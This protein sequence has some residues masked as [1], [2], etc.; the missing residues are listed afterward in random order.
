[1]ADLDELLHRETLRMPYVTI[2][3]IAR[4]ESSYRQSMSIRGETVTDCVVPE[5]LYEH[6]QAGAVIQFYALH[7]FFP[8]IRELVAML[9]DK[10]ASQGN[11]IAFM[12]PAGARTAPG[13][14]F[15]HDPVDLFVIQVE[16]SKT[17]KL[18]ATPEIRKGDTA[19]FEPDEL[20]EPV[21][22]ADLEPG[23]VLY[24]PYN[25][26]HFVTASNQVSLHLSVAVRP[27][28]WSELLV[29][30]VQDIVDHDPAFWAFPY[31]GSA[32]AGEQAAA[33][34]QVTG[35]LI[36]RLANADPG[37][38]IRMLAESGREIEG[39]APAGRGFADAASIDRVDEA[40]MFRRGQ[41]EVVFG[42]TVDGKTTLKVTA[43][44]K[45]RISGKITASAKPVT[46]KVPAEAAG[47]LRQMGQAGTV[48]AG[49]FLPGASSQRSVEAAKTLA[50]LGVLEMA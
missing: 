30:M 5:R 48:R 9:A 50:R 24:M 45:A 15:H 2:S 21:M 18:W 46:V 31:L 26:P 36:D 19:F 37:E 43:A 47:N 25:T 12:T 20:G 14:G 8:N 44:R 4:P 11:V 33:L 38:R 40:T 7:H 23:D 35:A 29:A 6:F 49:E 39:I 27:R 32:P 13:I 1:V 10:F 41:A 3:G 22:E 28:M 17:W 16:G 42:E 34:K